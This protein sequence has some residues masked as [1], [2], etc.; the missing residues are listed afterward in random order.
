MRRF[1][2]ILALFALTVFPLAAQNNPYDIDDECYALFVRAESLVGQPGFEEVNAELLHSAFSKGDT[3]AQTL[4]YVERLKNA[5]RCAPNHVT[6]TEEQ[7]ATV[8][9]AHEDTKHIADKLGYPQ[10]FYYSYELTQNYFYN[11][12]KPVRTMEL[13]HEMQEIAY[14]RGNE[15]G[16]WMGYR[17]LVSLYVAQN[18]YVS[19]KKYI[20]ESIRIHDKSTDPVVRKQSICRLYCD[21]ADCYPIGNDSVLINVEK[22]MAGKS[23]PCCWILFL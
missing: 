8:L 18:D 15:Y 14:E 3:K 6:T 13:V 19:A 12:K 17:Y 4:Y 5:T 11:H 2:C 20:K 10:Y 9:R 1:A 21:L 23:F 22:A 16:L 7:D